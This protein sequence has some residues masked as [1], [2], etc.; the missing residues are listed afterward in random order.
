[1]HTHYVGADHHFNL[2]VVGNMSDAHSLLAALRNAKLFHAALSD[3]EITTRA[4]A[5]ANT[6]IE[7]FLPGAKRR[8]HHTK[9]RRQ[10]STYP[11]VRESGIMSRTAGNPHLLSQE[12]SF[13]QFR[14]AVRIRPQSSV[15]ISRSFH[16]GGSQPM[17]RP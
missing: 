9:N 17:A 6:A 12:G 2:N 13:S 5:A 16:Q 15:F 8:R 11:G 4:M 3:H 1:M 10:T 7:L 14:A